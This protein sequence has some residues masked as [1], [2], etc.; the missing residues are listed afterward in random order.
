M[1]PMDK[2]M[3]PSLFRLAQLHAYAKASLNQWLAYNYLLKPTPAKEKDDMFQEPTASDI[4]KV[5]QQFI[6]RAQ[7]QLLEH[8]NSLRT[9]LQ[10]HRPDLVHCVDDVKILYVRPATSTSQKDDKK[11]TA[12]QVVTDYPDAL[13]AYLTE[14]LPEELKPYSL[15]GETLVE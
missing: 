8:K 4:A 10:K 15:K 9:L 1:I 2:K 3:L 13:Y 14:E 6:E 7:E 5:T 11:N 12:A